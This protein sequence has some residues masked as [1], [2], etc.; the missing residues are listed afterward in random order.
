MQR[1]GILKKLTLSRYGFIRFRQAGHDILSLSAQFGA[2]LCGL[3]HSAGLRR[4]GLDFKPVVF[5]ARQKQH[6]LA[7]G[8]LDGA[9][10]LAVGLFFLS[11]ALC[12]DQVIQ[13]TLKWYEGVAECRKAFIE[14]DP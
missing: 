10:G 14:D 9:Q 6:G 2:A 11:P 4:T 7:E 3:F 8:T 1:A 13:S 5:F 12:L